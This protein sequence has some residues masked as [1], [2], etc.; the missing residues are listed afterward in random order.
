MIFRR[1]YE[2]Y[3]ENDAI[4]NPALNSVANAANT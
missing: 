4:D 2:Y 1:T 3:Q